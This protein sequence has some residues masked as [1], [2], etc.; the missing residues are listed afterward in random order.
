MAFRNGR[1]DDLAELGALLV[2]ETML[3]FRSTHVKE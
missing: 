1:E 2:A 3:L